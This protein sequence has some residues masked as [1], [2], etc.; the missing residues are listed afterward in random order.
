MFEQTLVSEEKTNISWTVLV[1]FGGELVLVTT[2]VLIPLIYLQALPRTQLSNAF[3]LAP[4]PPQPPPSP[5]GALPRVAKVIPRAF[6]VGQLTAPVAV[7]KQVANLIEQEFAP[8]SEATGLGGVPGG[9]P[10][11]Q[12]G[13]VIGGIVGSIPS[14]GPPPP[15][16][17]PS[18]VQNELKAATPQ[19]IRLVSDIQ[20]GK[21]L[22]QVT[23]AYPV[24]ARRARVQG[25][26]RLNAVIGT[27]GMVREITVISGHPL[28]VQAAMQAA[29]QFMYR[30]TYQNGQAVEVKTEINVLFH[31]ES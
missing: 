6:V 12:I 19:R 25:A 23:P 28:L 15:P 14:A 7:P 1:A 2:L 24:A 18:P 16:P 30:P 9:V 17:P 21:L 3:F 20:A 22:H 11:G 26:V 5:W 31:L 4:P 10:G 8:P 27:D 13:G 29:R